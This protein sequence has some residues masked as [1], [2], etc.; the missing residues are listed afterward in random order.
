M[1]VFAEIYGLPKFEKDIGRLHKR[2][3]TIEDDLR[4]FIEKQLFLYH[5]LKVDNKGIFQ[6][7]GL[8]IE[9]A[10]VY[11]AKKFACRSLKGK[12]VQSGM[13]VIYAY[14]E[15]EDKIDL[16]E[17]YYKGDKANEDKRRILEY[18]SQNP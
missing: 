4:I 11:K 14:Y 18:L 9:D 3:T 12:G 7:V 5:K 2:F 15:N 6:I 8:T 13:R 17:I 10:K 1:S 16:I